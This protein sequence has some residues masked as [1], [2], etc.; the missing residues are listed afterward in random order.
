MKRRPLVRRVE[1]HK[2]H[3]SGST[4][5]IDGGYKGMVTPILE[6]KKEACSDWK[7]R[8]S[9]LKGFSI[10]EVTMSMFFSIISITYD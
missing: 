5:M 4:S 6:G 3:V 7:I 10:R 1:I 2:C 8:K 9:K